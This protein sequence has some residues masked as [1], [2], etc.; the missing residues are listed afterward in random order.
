MKNEWQHKDEWK[1]SGKGFIVQVT[2]HSTMLSDFAFDEGP[3]RWAVYTYIYP[4]HP[5]FAEIVGTDMCQDSTAA[6]P[7]HCGASY[8]VRHVHGGKEASIQV[9]EDYNHL[10]DSRYTHYETKEDA[11][12]VFMDAEE[13]FNWLQDRAA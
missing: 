3:H 4:Q 6:M 7:L 10:H 1:L 9:G 12:S 2:R 11:R 13:L 8:L 5:Y